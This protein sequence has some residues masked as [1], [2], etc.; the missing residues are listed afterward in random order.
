MCVWFYLTEYLKG[1]PLKHDQKI[2]IFN[3][4]TWDRKMVLEN[5]AEQQKNHSPSFSSSSSTSFLLFALL[6]S[7]FIS[8]HTLFCLPLSALSCSYVCKLGYN[9][10]TDSLEIKRGGG[11]F[12]GTERNKRNKVIK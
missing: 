5:Q 12:I 6:L 1:N 7:F 3:S 4:G 8:T 9:T 2:Y 11:F 10:R